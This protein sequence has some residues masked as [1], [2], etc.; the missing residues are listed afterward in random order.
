MAMVVQCADDLVPPGTWGGDGDGGWWKSW[1]C[2]VSETIKG[3]SKAWVNLSVK[4]TAL[5][6]HRRLARPY[7]QPCSGQEILT[8]RERKM[9]LVTA[10]Q[11]GIGVVA[12][13]ISSD[14]GRRRYHVTM[15][16]RENTNMIVEIA[17]ISGVMPRRRRPHISSGRVL[18]RPMRKKLTAIS[19]IESVKMSNAAPMMESA[20]W[21]CDSPERL[22]VICAEIERGFFLRAIEFL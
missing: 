14:F 10:S 18:S 13:P 5:A 16:A 11:D 22:P 21:E 3:Y 7:G 6:P 1:M 9:N 12:I 15:A 20:D 4:D 17:L 19:S 8:A 2:R